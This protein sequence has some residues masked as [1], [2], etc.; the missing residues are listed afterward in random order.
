MAN[1]K[2]DAK[3]QARELFFTTNLK[4]KTIAERIGVAERTL[5]IWVTE[6]NWKEQKRMHFHAPQ[7][8]IHELYEELRAISQNIARRPPEA[9][10]PTKEELE[11]RTKLIALINSLSNMSFGQWRN[12]PDDHELYLPPVN[13]Q[14]L[15]NAKLN[16]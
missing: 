14:P 2:T 13:D 1:C 6:G 11:A 8:E 7:V 9:R 3:E 15:Q 4:Q 16:S 12:I 5:S 10:F